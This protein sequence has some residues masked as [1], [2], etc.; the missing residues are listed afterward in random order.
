MEESMS[1]LA[2]GTTSQ[3]L[4]D[5]HAERHA[6]DSQVNVRADNFTKQQLLQVLL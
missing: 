6:F 5:K 2:S 3:G 1:I 4:F